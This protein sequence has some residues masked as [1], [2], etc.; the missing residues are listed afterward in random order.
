MSKLEQAVAAYNA[1]VEEEAARLTAHC[2]IPLRDAII[3]AK[4][5]VTPYKRIAREIKIK[6]L[7]FAS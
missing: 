3:Q 2:G 4:R 1:E 7:P 5:I 6:C